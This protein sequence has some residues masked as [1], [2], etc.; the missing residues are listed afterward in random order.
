MNQYTDPVCLLNL[1]F[2]IP[3]NFR[4]EVSM[5]TTSSSIAVKRKVWDLMKRIKIIVFFSFE[6]HVLLL[7]EGRRNCS[8]TNLTEEYKYKGHCNNSV[9]FIL[10]HCI[11]M[12]SHKETNELPKYV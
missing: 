11:F 7:S 3:L 8:K 2:T 10:F 12:L 9:T 5:G 4:E 6:F 1:L